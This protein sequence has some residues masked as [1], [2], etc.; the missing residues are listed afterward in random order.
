MNKA[1][2][3]LVLWVGW[4]SIATMVYVGLYLDTDIVSFLRD[5]QSKITWIILLLFLV[6]VAASFF[7]TVN[8]TVEH[9][10]A[11]TQE[12]L[13]R[14][15]GLI[16]V[17]SR[18]RKK[19]AVNRFFDSLRIVAASNDQPNIDAL[20]EME[21]GSH[22]RVSQAL[23]ILGNLLITLGLIG[24]VVG[25]TYTLSGLTS[26][27]SALGQDTDLLLAGLRKAMAGMGTSFYTTLLGALLGG[28]L[29]RIFALITENGI[30]GLHE[31]LSRTCMLYCTAD[32]KQTAERE[33]RLL[34]VEIEALGDRL[35]ALNK[36]F[37]ESKQSLLEFRDAV[38]ELHTLSG[39]DSSVY[40]LRE[41][42]RMQKYYRALLH[43][44]IH[45]MNKLNRS[46]WQRFERYLVS[47]KE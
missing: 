20:L 21:F 31:A 23:E 32:L 44:E 9:L 42:L 19:R 13:A 46:W 14:E 35:G 26:S 36:A 39:E 40:T 27:L 24:T 11:L 43:H 28:V 33:V 12:K 10:E 2:R 18:G 34:N 7:L 25:L 41:T 3:T 22:I 6:G 38:K 30:S 8:V 45:L 4:C 16:G 47:R 15:K 5:D 37:S 1:Y 29:L 17:N